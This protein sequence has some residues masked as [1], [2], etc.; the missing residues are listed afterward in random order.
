MTR[1][2]MDSAYSTRN[3]WL[4][5]Y[6]YEVA[7]R[8]RERSSRTKFRE[9]SP[10]AYLYKKRLNLASFNY[11]EGKPCTWYSLNNYDIV[12][13]AHKNH[14]IRTCLIYHAAC[15]VEFQPFK[16]PYSQ[17]TFFNILWRLEEIIRGEIFKDRFC[18]VRVISVGYWICYRTGG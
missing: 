3:T 14:I 2:L 6:D 10:E 8:L 9:R 11:S 16:R 17:L 5:P 15:K 13:L 4:L 18:R 1:W 12:R 7:R